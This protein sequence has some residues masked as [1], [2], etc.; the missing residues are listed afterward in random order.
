MQ[1]D[2]RGDVVR[3]IANDDERLAS[4]ARGGS[5]VKAEDILLDNLDLGLLNG[6]AAAERGG[7]R[8]IEF[9]G[10]QMCGARGQQIGDG[11]ATR[12]D[13]D[14]GARLE[15]TKRGDDALDGGVVMQEVLAES[16]FGRQGVARFQWH[17]MEY[18]ERSRLG[19]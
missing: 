19:V 14:D 7:K 1:Q 16:G 11:S 13:L 5:E 10:D 8:G 3:Q 12:A 18:V 6:V 4:R 17:R 15:R 9:D 2:G